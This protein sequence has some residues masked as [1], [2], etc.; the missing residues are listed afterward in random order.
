MRISRVSRSI[1]FLSIVSVVLFSA[2]A[3]Y[4]RSESELEQLASTDLIPEIRIAAG[5]ALTSY[6]LKSKSISELEDLAVNGASDGFRLAAGKALSK[7]Y[8]EEDMSYEEL[9]KIG[10]TGESSELRKAVIPAL[11]EYLIGKKPEELKDLALDSPTSALRSAATEAFFFLKKNEFKEPTD[12]IKVI[13]GESEA[14]EKVNDEI[15]DYAARLLAGAWIGYGFKTE[16]ELEDLALND[17]TPEI[18]AAVG[19][20]LGNLWIRSDKTEQELLQMA[21]NNA[22]IQTEAHRNAIVMALADRFKG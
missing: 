12:L 5:T 9:L 21:V 10:E 22:F 4:A 14:F 11:Q 17:E 7:L 20:A 13:K 6:W 2:V 8:L 16:V 18:R 15:K 3:L 19:R 1:V